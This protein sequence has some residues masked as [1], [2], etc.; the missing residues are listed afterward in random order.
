MNLRLH[1]RIL[2]NRSWQMSVRPLEL[3]RGDFQMPKDSLNLLF[4][5]QGIMLSC[6]RQRWLLPID[7]GPVAHITDVV[8][9]VVKLVKT[10]S[11]STKSLICYILDPV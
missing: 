5:H 8:L 2:G 4:P 9:P 3:T 11:I 7:I 1:R 6:F 10:S